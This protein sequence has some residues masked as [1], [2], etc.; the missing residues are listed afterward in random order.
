MPLPI[1]FISCLID[2]KFAL[3]FGFG[4][5]KRAAWW[6]WWCAHF[7]VNASSV[8]GAVIQS[9]C[10][11]LCVC[12]PLQY[13]IGSFLFC[14]CQCSV[15]MCQM[16]AIGSES[17]ASCCSQSAGGFMGYRRRSAGFFDKINWLI[18]E[19]EAGMWSF[20]PEQNAMEWKLMR[21]IHCF[22]YTLGEQHVLRWICFTK[23]KEK[24]RRLSC[25]RLSLKALKSSHVLSGILVDFSDYLLLI[26]K[27]TRQ[28]SEVWFQH[29]IFTLI[30]YVILNLFSGL[31]GNGLQYL[32]E[33]QKS[34]RFYCTIALE[35]GYSENIDST[36][37]YFYWNIPSRPN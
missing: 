23:R 13:L 11:C 4:R 12:V 8:W 27:W 2:R 31:I 14:V 34:I 21:C 20:R 37:F 1:I 28:H 16:W 24:N 25:Q 33:T 5:G 10:I 30:L 22:W 35:L 19:F 36:G 32:W 3:S 18:L 26:P 7:H 17:A 15:T 29:I 9:L 6:K